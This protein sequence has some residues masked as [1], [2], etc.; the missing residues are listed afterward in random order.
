MPYCYILYSEKANKYYIG[1]TS[2]EPESR[3]QK[4]VQ[5]YYGKKKY[6][7][8]TNDWKIFWVQKCETLFMAGK[9]ESHIKKM[10]SRMYI[11]NLKKY[12]EIIHQFI[13]KYK[14]EKPI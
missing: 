1:K 11:E 5:N 14:E 3:L 9:I 6:T 4:H 8:F 7:H 10:K 13:I 12:P 2:D